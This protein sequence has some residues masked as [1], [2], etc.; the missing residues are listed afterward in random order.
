MKIVTD[1]HAHTLVSGHAYNTMKEMAKAAAEHGMEL[2]A[3]T[4]HAPQMPGTCGPFYFQNLKIVPRSMYGIDLLLGVELNIMNQDGEV[5]LP[6]ETLREMDIVI[7]SI[8]GPCYGMKHTREENTRAYVKAMQNP[9]IH[10]IGHPDDGRFPVDYD[11]VARTAKE[12]GTLLEINN[13]S[14]RP[15]GFRVG[16]KEN[17]A[18]MLGFCKTYQAPVV[19][20][21]DAHVDTEMGVFSYAEELLKEVDFPEELVV[22]TS[23]ERLKDYIHF[24]K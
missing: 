22:S 1:T 6:E 5:D 4:E 12:T 3:L 8:H 20:S 21:S 9:Y 10:I 19:V 15:G 18:E 14:L 16:T 2:A 7:A 13:S 24:K 17:A 11:I 23:A